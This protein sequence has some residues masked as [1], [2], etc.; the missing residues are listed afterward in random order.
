MSDLWT[1]LEAYVRSYLPDWQFRR[2]GPE[3]ESALLTVLG[4][5]LEDSRERLDRLPDK[6]WAEFLSAWDHG[7]GASEPMYAYAALTAPHS[8]LIPKGSSFYRSG[9]GTRLWRTLQ[10]AWAE[11][12]RPTAQVFSD[13]RSGKLLSLPAPA[14]DAPVRLFDFRGPGM[15]AREVRFRHP[16]AFASGSGCD[17]TLRLE[18]GTDELLRFLSGREDVEWQLESEGAEQPLDTPVLAERELRF[19][20]PPHKQAASLLVRVGDGRIPPP[21]P[22]RRALVETR[23]DWGGPVCVMLEG[24]PCQDAVWRPFGSRLMQWSACYLSC[25]DALCLPGAEVTIAWRQSFLLWDERLPDMEQEPEYRP[26]MRRL[27]RQPPPARDVRADSVLWEYWDGAVWRAIPGTDGC[28]RLFSDPG[29]QARSEKQMQA[30]FRW[31]ADAARCEVQGVEDFWLRWRLRS[32]EG[33]GWLPACYHAPQVSQLRISACLP[34][35]EAE[36]ERRCGLHGE[37]TPLAGDPE[38]ILFPSITGKQDSWWLGF[39]LPP[40]GESTGLYLDLRGRV[41]GGRLSAWEAEP[42]GG[43]RPLT[44]SDQTGGLAHSGPL[45]LSGLPGQTSVRFGL[46]RWWICLREESGAF[47]RSGSTPVLQGLYCGAVPLCAY[48]DDVCAPGDVFQPLHGGAVKAAALTASF[49]GVRAETDRDVLRRLRAQRHHLGRAVS[50][51]DADQLICGAVR[52]VVRTRC[53]REGSTLRVGVLMRD[54]AQHSAAFERK[55]H[56]IRQLLL[57]QS[58]IPSLGLSLQI[59]EP[60][61]YPI[62]VMAWVRA[63]DGVSFEESRRQL[64]MALDRFLDPAAGN[65]RGFGW[66]MGELPTAMQLRTCLQSA[67]PGVRLLELVASAA[68]PDGKERQPSSVRDPFAL[69]APGVYTI[70]NLKGGV[71]SEILRL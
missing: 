27:P 42:G 21:G 66:H 8:V 22:V 65:F 56:E 18:G 23:R 57:K 25:P 35:A 11:P 67:V 69:P 12:C 43:E 9:D 54:T 28:V 61:F 51:L 58:P 63:P 70:L 39:D 7:P 60:C 49:G 55:R 52:D 6:H 14:R 19:R 62:H 32:C 38:H 3:V 20:L 36:M 5:M 34:P 53:V 31:P 71:R 15:Q 33:A 4:E 26:I 37:F 59:R 68:A 41:P 29:G 40:G 30:T 64:R 10:D 1:Q 17:L 47:H 2:G 16:S 46:E 45:W 24:G 13:S 44:L 48:G 50:A